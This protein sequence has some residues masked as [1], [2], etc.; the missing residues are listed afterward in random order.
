MAGR[1][2]APIRAT[3]LVGLGLAVPGPP[4][5]AARDPKPIDP[6]RV[7]YVNIDK[8]LRGYERAKRAGAAITE[9]RLGYVE[10]VK[11]ERE[12]LDGVNRQL[13]GATAD[14]ERK[15][16]RGR[17]EE[18]EE[19]VRAVDAEAQRVLTKLSDETLLAVF[20]EVREILAAVAKDRSLDVIE[21]FR[22]SAEDPAFLPAQIAQRFLEQPALVPWFIKPELDLTA[23]VT[24]RLNAA[25][26]PE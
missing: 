16:L 14:E 13:A 15:V 4:P 6:P 26:P 11:K 5:S 24:R 12:A 19:R 10:R 22:L 8:V 9:R 3:G 20:G 1:L 18:I 7:G 17:A 23:E 2:S 21:A 25:H